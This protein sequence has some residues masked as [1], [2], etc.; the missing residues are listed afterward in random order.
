MARKIC[1][2]ILSLFGI[3]KTF[4]PYRAYWND[5]TIGGGNDFAQ[6]YCAPHLIAGHH[7]YDPPA[8]DAEQDRI[9]PSV[10]KAGG[11]FWYVRLPYYAALLWPLSQLPYRFAYYCWQLVALGSIAAFICVC[12]GEEAADRHPVLLVSRH[13]VQFCERA[14]R[15]LFAAVPGRQYV[16]VAQ[17]SSLRRGPGA[18]PVPGEVPPD[19]L[20]SDRA[21]GC[22]PVE[23]VL[24]FFHGR[25]CD[26]DSLFRGGRMDVAGG[27][28]PRYQDA[29]SQPESG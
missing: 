10:R 27:V 28:V 7:L 8:M 20:S 11:P 16:P 18:L 6:L 9:I 14:G 22:P 13:P 19:P 25:S 15:S 23:V 4:A 17:E 24:R 26:A 3:W 12:A 2:L 29:D 1:F 21:A 5:M